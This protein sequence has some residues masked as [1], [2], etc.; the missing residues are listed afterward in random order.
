MTKSITKS[1]YRELLQRFKDRTAFIKKATVETLIGETPEQQQ[2]RIKMLL[3][4]ENYG[5][6]FNY[7]FGKDTP[8]PMADS[9][10]AWYHT[11][12]YKDLYNKAYI[13]LFNLIF[14]GGAKS[15]HANMG[16]PFALKQAEKAKY[17][18]TVGINEKRAAELLQDLQV[19]FEYNERI[20]KDF[21]RQKLLGSWADGQFETPD[22]CTFMALGLNQPMR[23][24]RQNGVRLEYASIDD[25]ED[26][27]TAMNK[28]LVREYT[29]KI[30]GDIQ[31]AFSKRSERTI[32]NNNY[33]VENGIVGLLL[34]KKGFDLK[35]IDTK[36][37][38]VIKTKYSKLYLVNL[39]DKDYDEI[40]TDRQ[41]DSAKNAGRDA[42]NRVSTPAY[43]FQPSWAERYTHEDCLRKIEQ[44]Q[45]DKETLSGEFY[46]TP[47]NAGKRIKKEM[48]K[49]VK[50]QPFDQYVVI[51]GNWDFAY[52]DAACYKAMATVGV[53]GMNMTVI[54][55]F[56]RQTANIDTALA[57]HY[58]QAKKIVKINGATLFYYDGSVAQE[59]IYTPVLLRAAMQHKSFAIP[60]PQKSTVDK[61]IKIDTVLVSALIT[62]ILNFSEALEQNPDWK[63]AKAQMLNFEKGGKYPVD[64]PDALTDAILKA[65]EYLNG[66]KDDGGKSANTP[67]IGKRKRGGY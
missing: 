34:E 67:V 55:L 1:E 8:V 15:T 64:F 24:I 42:I 12:I 13:T 5:L 63:E 29:E 47:I 23:G 32:I 36:H 27:K 48:L 3:K 9:P 52:S 22:R 45:N 66:D 7:Y 44:Y 41:T 60:I 35:N 17:F 4:P 19:Q 38:Q 37:N 26:K 10:C 50:P 21:G 46:N 11:A 30:T 57:Y 6:F 25:C 43:D 39:T 56:C 2:A 33:F 54:D 62:G 51:V 16:Y 59:A 58:T 53:S 28:R 18:L 61:Y 14:R 31:G 65:Q 20:I 49:M 40:Q